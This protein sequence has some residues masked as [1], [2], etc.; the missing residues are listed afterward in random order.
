MIRDMANNKN[1]R[2][3]MDWNTASLNLDRNKAQIKPFNMFNSRNA[4]LYGGCLTPLYKK[5]LLAANDRGGVVDRNGHL[6]RI[7]DNGNLYKDDTLIAG[8]FNL[9]Y[10]KTKVSERYI[11]SDKMMGTGTDIISVFIR[12]NKLVFRKGDDPE[13]SSEIVIETLTGQEL[14]YDVVP[15]KNTSGSTF[16]YIYTVLIWRNGSLRKI[17]VESQQ[18]TSYGEDIAVPT[19]T[20]YSNPFISAGIIALK[21]NGATTASDCIGELNSSE[22]LKNRP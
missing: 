12:D 1:E 7:A 9:T 3:T 19:Y 18:M 4:P 13:Y 22:R 21:N 20:N 15:V 8:G 16:V 5:N 2:I 10:S 17:F 11:F 14:A 6:W